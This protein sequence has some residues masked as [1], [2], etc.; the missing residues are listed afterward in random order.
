MRRFT[1]K[2][3]IVTGATG[4]IGAAIAERLAREGARVVVC[5]RN[6]SAGRAL[7][8]RLGG[9][10]L[11]GDVRDPATAERA[12]VAASRLDVL[13]QQCRYGPHGRPVGGPRGRRSGTFST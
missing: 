4:G 10:F 5:G 7:A 12:V 1:N 2:T 3:A 9:T 13:V 8:D 6:E 11:G